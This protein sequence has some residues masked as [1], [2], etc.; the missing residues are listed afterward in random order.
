MANVMKLVDTVFDLE[1][2]LDSIE[3][4][5]LV[6]GGY[7]APDEQARM[8]KK[9]LDGSIRIIK[10]YKKHLYS[11]PLNAVSATDYALFL[12]WWQLMQ[13][14]D[15]YPDLINDGATS[16]AIKIVNTTAPLSLMEGREDLYEGTLNIREV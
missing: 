8:V 11:I 1:W 5:P 12:E 16:Y 9:M 10:P 2:E 6:D 3:F 7:S 13:E 4:S 14:L 15:F